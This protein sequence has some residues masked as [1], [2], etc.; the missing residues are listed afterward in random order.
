MK[1]TKKTDIIFKDRFIVLRSTYDKANIRYVIQ[2]CKDKY[3]KYPSCVKKVKNFDDIANP[4]MIMSEKERDLYSEGKIALFPENQFF[5]IRS[6]KTYDLEDMWQKAEWECI[7][8]CPLIA[9]DRF[10]KDSKGNLVIDGNLDYKH[11]RYGVAELYIDRPGVDTQRRVSK[12][13][14]IHKAESFIL[15]DEHGLE[16]NLNMARLLGKNMLN[17]YAADV[18]DF[19]LRVAEKDPQKIINL[20]TGTDTSLRLLFIEAKDK[21]VI[22]IKNKLYIYGDDI[23]LG[24]TDDSVI[25]WMQD[26]KNKR[27]LELI[28]KET[29][30]DYESVEEN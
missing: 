13:Q 14:L 19:L 16:G 20:Y 22:R 12:K 8:N 6:G 17:Q 10:E 2:A 1:E 28:K 26:P 25:A 3:G 11:P 21:K 23:A 4:E 29:F 9:K 15:N 7:K 30:E 24:A 5:E 27:I 18:T